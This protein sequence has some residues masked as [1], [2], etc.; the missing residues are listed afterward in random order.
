MGHFEL[1]V[2]FCSGQLIQSLL[3]PALLWLLFSMTCCSFLKVFREGF[4][5]YVR[6]EQNFMKIVFKNKYFLCAEKL[7]FSILNE[8]L[9]LQDLVLFKIL[10]VNCDLTN[11]SH[12]HYHIIFNFWLSLFSFLTT[13]FSGGKVR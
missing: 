7:T 13:L 9:Y 11:N 1:R 6:N 10:F 2:W 8:K 5:N 12:H 3:Y 4:E